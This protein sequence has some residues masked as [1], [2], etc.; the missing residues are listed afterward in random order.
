M[1]KYIE[2]LPVRKIISS[3]VRRKYQETHNFSPSHQVSELVLYSNVQCYHSCVTEFL[4]CLTLGF[5]NALHSKVPSHNKQRGHIWFKKCSGSWLSRRQNLAISALCVRCLVQNH[6]HLWSDS[7]FV[8]VKLVA[9]C[10]I[11]D[12]NVF[13]CYCCS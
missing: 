6:R 1:H 11:R 9:V 12:L 5:C 13:P 8:K 7:L 4:L 10:R 3:D 2:S